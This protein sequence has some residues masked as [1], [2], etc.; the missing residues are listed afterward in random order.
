M[1]EKTTDKDLPKPLRSHLLQSQRGQKLATEKTNFVYKMKK[2]P[3]GNPKGTRKQRTLA[4]EEPILQ[5]ESLT[6]WEDA[7]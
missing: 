3:L 1:R 4:E 7:G 5:K 2:T 6:Y